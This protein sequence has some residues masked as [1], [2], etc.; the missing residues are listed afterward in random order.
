MT[1]I[2]CDKCGKLCMTL[3]PGSKTRNGFVIY[4]SKRCKEPEK[5]KSDDGAVNEIMKMFGM[6]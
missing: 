2:L 3:T 4:C 6:K 1:N 5:P